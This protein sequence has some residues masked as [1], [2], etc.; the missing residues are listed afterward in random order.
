MRKTGLLMACMAL[1][2]ALLVL[3]GVAWAE[4]YATPDPAR[5]DARYECP[6]SPPAQI[7]PP[8]LSYNQKPYIIRVNPFRGCEIT[9]T[10][11]TVRATVGD[12]TANLRNRDIRFFFD[13]ERKR[14]FDYSRRTDRPVYVRAR[15][16]ALGEH[17]VK[18]VA[19]DRTGDTVKKRTKRWSF[20]VVTEVS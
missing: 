8:D 15:P 14:T 9:D 4:G 13:G 1:A 10:T 7:P 17:T 12:D 5:P 16:V 2:A 18:I 3:T 20:K 11:P 6:S 19:V